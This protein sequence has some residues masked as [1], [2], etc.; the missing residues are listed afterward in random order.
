MIWL[1]TAVSLIAS[2][3]FFFKLPISAEIGKATQSAK[4]ALKIILASGISDH[5]KEKI[6]LECALRIFIG[7][8]KALC[9]LFLALMPTY[10]L[11]FFSHSAFML[12][13]TLPGIGFSFF[14]SISYIVVRRRVIG[15]L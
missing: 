12:M 14:V 13:M 3:E 8:S 6:V 5:S 10:L 1:F 2:L 9:L 11:L 15:R 4:K 7:S